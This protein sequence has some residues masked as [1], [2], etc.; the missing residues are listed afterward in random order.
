M[1]NN[2]DFYNFHMYFLLSTYFSNLVP[3]DLAKLHLSCSMK[4]YP[5]LKGIYN[6]FDI[7][8]KDS[9]SDL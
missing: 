5:K 6:M 2:K 3:D 4:V 9:I 7:F 1:H 8:G